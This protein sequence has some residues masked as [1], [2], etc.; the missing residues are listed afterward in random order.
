MEI[1]LRVEGG[2]SWQGRPVPGDRLRSLLTA[3][4]AAHPDGAGSA[5]LIRAVWGEDLPAHPLKALQILVSRARGATAPEV[6]ER[7]PAG[8][9]LGLAPGSVDVLARAELA[10]AADAA[11]TAGEPVR[12]G[13]HARAALALGP[14]PRAR[15]V[16]ALADSRLGR[17]GH[18]LGDLEELVAAEPRDEELQ[19]ALLRELA[20]TRGPGAALARFEAIRRGL[21]EDLGTG[22]G[23]ALQ[24][25]HRELLASDRPVRSGVAHAA[26][27]LLGRRADLEAVRGMLT[28]ARLVSIIGTG[29]LGKTRLAQEIAAT[30]TRPAVHVVELAGVSAPGEVVG[31]VATALNM[32][33]SVSRPGRRGLPADLPSRVAGQLEGAP[34]LLVLDNC[35]HVAGA[36]ADLVAFLLSQVRDL[37]VLTTSR[38][39]LR[40][41]AE[42]VYALG[43]LGADDAARLF[44]D[45]ATAVRPGAVVEESDVA[46]LVERLDGL[47]LAIEL[48]AATVRT[49]S[50]PQILARLP[51]RFALLQGGDR[52]A[53]RRHRTLEAV[54]DWSW[55]LLD[56]GA[57]DALAR[58]SAWPDGFTAEAAQSMLG[59]DAPGAVAALVDQSLLGIDESRGLP[60]YRML[61][62]IREYGARHLARAGRH[63][64][65]RASVRAWAAGACREYLRGVYGPGQLD[66]LDALHR[67][68]ATLADVL[69]EAFER[70]EMDVAVPV[71]AALVSSWLICGEHLRI[72]DSFGPVERLLTG[73]SVPPELEEE[74]RAGLSILAVTWAMLPVSS[75]LTQTHR[76]L[77]DLRRQPGRDPVVSALTRIAG[78]L[79]DA[80]GRMAP[81]VPIRLR[82]LA[83]DPDRLTAVVA[84][85]FLALHLENAGD[86]AGAV[87]TLERSLGRMAPEDPP[88][89]LANHHAILAQ[90]HGQ[91]GQFEASRAEAR[92]ALPVLERLGAVEDV[93]QCRAVIAAAAL[94]AGDLAAAESA[95]REIAA[96][97]RRGRGLGAQV[98]VLL[99]L[100]EISYAR[101]EVSSARALLVEV[102]RRG[103]DARALSL[104]APDGLDPW[105]LVTRAATLAV[106]T[107]HDP[108]TPDVFQDAF[109]DLVRRARRVSDP[110]RRDYDFPVL[111]TVCF[112][113]AAAGM[114]HDR[115]EPVDVAGLLAL[116]DAFGYNRFLPS[117]AREPLAGAVA[118][119]DPLALPAATRALAGHRG[120]DLVPLMHERIGLIARAGSS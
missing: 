73:R 112:A 83:A 29:G 40:L 76:V 28:T 64:E 49:M 80:P 52:S 99:G 53:P 92:R 6:I 85:P 91:L 3:L 58:L 25:V 105:A 89:L 34:S 120:A 32:R 41:T 30:S 11:L 63:A 46:L 57:Q 114:L 106:R 111:G 43:G 50:V 44:R 31:A 88:W 101:G 118:A 8:Y 47:P 7:T 71:F 82:G 17:F 45:R 113:L 116:A 108:D 87:H 93:L 23:P 72:V 1:R 27:S 39:P 13:A 19:A 119:R 9:R 38:A 79:A 33:E 84:A 117:L 36:V 18:D 81:L 109:D 90:L 70:G 69:R 94:A 21:R 62:T 4:A 48:A 98:A 110:V 66:V 22:P 26:T 96:Q 24:A 35:E 37:R 51:D 78:Q 95:L 68:E 56:A 5:A 102:G 55:Q 86:P 14:D 20:A 16:L 59:A 15:R 77:A 67:E 74:A 10:R 103:D 42:H 12:A 97:Q 100:A 65:A 60:R 2:V 115:L 61:E 54:I 107:R 104:P 75:P